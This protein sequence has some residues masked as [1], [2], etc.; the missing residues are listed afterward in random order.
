MLHYNNE[1]KNTETVILK[2][3]II[4]IIIVIN[5][6]WKYLIFVTVHLVNLIIMV[7]SLLRVSYSEP[8][9]CV[10]FNLVTE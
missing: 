3:A 10:F 6:L 9:I 2:E 7:V 5:F 1:N 8:I 4:I